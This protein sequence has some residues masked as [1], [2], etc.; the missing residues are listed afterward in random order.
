M[1]FIAPGQWTLVRLVSLGC[2]ACAT[3][4]LGASETASGKVRDDCAR[5]LAVSTAEGYVLSQSHSLLTFLCSL[6][7]ERQDLFPIA[8]YSISKT[9]GRLRECQTQ[10][11][12]K[13]RQIHSV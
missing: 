6:F 7:S 13:I 12:S 5:V 8:H 10:S 9:T 2:K 4:L 11:L 3:P 1:K